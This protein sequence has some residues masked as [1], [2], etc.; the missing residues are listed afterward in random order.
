M[1]IRFL[2]S[3]LL[4]LLLAIVAPVILII[5]TLCATHKSL[6]RLPWGLNSL[7]GC[8][9][10]GW[11]GN[12]IDPNNPRRGWEEGRQG[13]WVEEDARNPD[14]LY[15]GWWFDYKDVSYSRLSFLQRW[16]LSYQ[17]CALR[18]V[19]WNLRLTKLAANTHYQQ[20]QLD[21]LEVSGKTATV[22]WIGA[23]GESYFFKRSSLG[24]ILIEWGWE[25]YPEYFIEDTLEYNRIR[26]HGYT[27]EYKYKTKSIVSV[28]FRRG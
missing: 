4:R 7:F 26:N 19:A 1:Y 23:N 18:N 25:F 13:K 15:Q 3:F 16:W 28:R 22:E 8:E 14:S 21:Y 20:I 2:F 11:N 6:D 5:P 27:R 9:E 10:D 17:W 24:F 12:G